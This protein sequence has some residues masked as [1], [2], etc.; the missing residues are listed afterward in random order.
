MAVRT[1]NRV[2]GDKERIASGRLWQGYTMSVATFVE[3]DRLLLNS[4]VYRVRIP[5]T[6]LRERG[7]EINVIHIDNLYKSKLAET[8]LIERELFATNYEYMRAMGIKRIVLTFDDAYDLAVKGSMTYDY[9]HKDNRL[10]DWKQTMR[11][12]DAV[13][14]PSHL[15]AKNYGAK[16]VPNYHDPKYWP[17]AANHTVERNKSSLT[18]GWGGTAAHRHT[19]ENSQLA[20]ALRTVKDEFGDSIKFVFYGGVAD[21][22]IHANNVPAELRGFV[23]FDEWPNVVRSFD[24]GLAPLASQYD[25]NRSNLKVLEYGLAGVPWVAT[26]GGEYMDARGGLIVHNKAKEWRWAL[27]ELIEKEELRMTLGQ[28]GREWAE[29]YLADRAAN[30]LT[31]ERILWPKGQ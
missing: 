26:S 7:H 4:S 2:A 9:W 10:A 15:L 11:R 13:I 6:Y 20:S 31:Y 25:Y 23:T 30:M 5:A 27:S 28:V 21:D 18:L 14:V 24:I 17:E 19:W 1:K 8:V 29:T 16:F 12:A 22:A 3:A